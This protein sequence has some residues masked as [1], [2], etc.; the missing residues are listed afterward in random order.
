[1]IDPF[2]THPGDS[3][4][5]KRA[6]KNTP[7]GVP[8]R[9]AEASFQGLSSESTVVARC[10]N[11]LYFRCNEMGQDDRLLVRLTGVVLNDELMV[12]FQIQLSTRRQ[13]QYTSRQVCRVQAQPAWNQLRLNSLQSS[14]IGG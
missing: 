4:S 5:L 8:Q 1:M 3:C 11:A 10:F 14:L 2:N 9:Y 13:T 12:K 7:E 6:Q